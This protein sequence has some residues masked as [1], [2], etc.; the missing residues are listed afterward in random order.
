MMRNNAA[1]VRNEAQILVATTR[2]RPPPKKE[3]PA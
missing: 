2:R 3:K 1:R